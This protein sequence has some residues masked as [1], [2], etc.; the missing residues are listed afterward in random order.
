[1]Y[2]Y[3]TSSILGELPHTRQKSL[4]FSL[5]AGAMN[6]IISVSTFGGVRSAIGNVCMQYVHS[7][8]SLKIGKNRKKGA[9]LLYMSQRKVIE[10]VA[11]VDYRLWSRLTTASKRYETYVTVDQQTL[12]KTG[13]PHFL[14]QFAVC[15]TLRLHFLSLSLPGIYCSPMGNKVGGDPE[16]AVADASA[17]VNDADWRGMLNPPYTLFY[18]PL[19]KV[20]QVSSFLILGEEISC[21]R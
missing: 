1:M 18:L 5:P 14:W 8:D 20:A 11:V 21:T 17:G 4:L 2:Q 6:A 12:S 13:F 19:R 15:R 3:K 10:H 16:A 7:T 9:T